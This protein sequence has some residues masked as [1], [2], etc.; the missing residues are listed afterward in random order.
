MRGMCVT[1]R[2]HGERYTG[3]EIQSGNRERKEVRVRDGQKSRDS[4]GEW[5]TEAQK[6]RRMKAGW[7]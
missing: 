4:A 7:W 6:L 1:G 3:T 2:Q 5:T